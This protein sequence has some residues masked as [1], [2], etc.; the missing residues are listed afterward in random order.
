[1]KASPLLEQN[2]HRPRSFDC[3]TRSVFHVGSYLV[4]GRVLTAK[5][6][7]LHPNTQCSAKFP[8][9]QLRSPHSQ[10]PIPAPYDFL[11]MSTGLCGFH[12]SCSLWVHH[13]DTYTVTFYGSNVRGNWSV[14]AVGYVCIVLLEYSCD[15]FMLWRDNLVLL[16]EHTEII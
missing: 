1:M 8:G 2:S 10:V 11:T 7:H 13:N 5:I 16:I 14:G 15:I 9:L 6:P 4:S 3:G 12:P